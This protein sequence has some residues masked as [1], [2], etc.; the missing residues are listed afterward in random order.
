[1]QE[2][3]NMILVCEFRSPLNLADKDVRALQ[4]HFIGI[5]QPFIKL[6][7]FLSHACHGEDQKCYVIHSPSIFTIAK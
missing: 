4:G 6:F 3:H 2:Q 1:M 5:T 7:L